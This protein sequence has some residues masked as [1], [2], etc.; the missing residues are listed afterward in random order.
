ML[1]TLEWIPVSTL[2]EPGT[3]T[4]ILLPKGYGYAYRAFYRF[5]YDANGH[6]F[7]QDQHAYNLKVYEQIY[8]VKENLITH[9][10]P[11][12]EIPEVKRKPVT[13]GGL[14]DV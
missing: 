10:Y 9:W 3:L 7:F 11:V 1:P 5:D 4:I 8:L 6:P 14:D 13:S 12:P 2:P